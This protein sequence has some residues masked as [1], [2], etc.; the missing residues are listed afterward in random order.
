ML[1]SLLGLALFA[2]YALA[3]PHK[4]A[5]NGAYE[6]ETRS[7]H[8]IYEAALAEGGVITLWHGGDEKTQQHF[9]KQAFEARFPNMTR[10]VTVDLSKYHDDNFDL[11]LAAENVYVDSSNL[12]NFTTTLAGRRKMLCSSTPR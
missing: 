11:Q 9:L 10:N 7:M 2:E 3:R 12:P 8:E 1:S 6:Q 4:Q 5:V